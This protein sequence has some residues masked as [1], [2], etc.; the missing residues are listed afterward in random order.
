M[1]TT[2]CGCG[3]MPTTTS[4]GVVHAS[5]RVNVRVGARSGIIACSTHARA[6]THTLRRT[7]KKN[8]AYNV[9]KAGNA[10]SRRLALRWRRLSVPF[11]MYA[12]KAD[13]GGIRALLCDRKMYYTPRVWQSIDVKK[14]R[15][16]N[17]LS[18][19]FP[20]VKNCAKLL[21]DL[22]I[23]ILLFIQSCYKFV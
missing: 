8:N 5:A 15:S 20:L 22:V 23:W 4:S 14:R 10:G 12:P 2:R 17:I 9:D 16:F 6:H 13:G 11:N 18:S 7:G 19:F 3:C 21:Q 1:W